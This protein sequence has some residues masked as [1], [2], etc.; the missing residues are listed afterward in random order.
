MSL[1]FDN[2]YNNEDQHRMNIETMQNAEQMPKR[3]FFINV[4]EKPVAKKKN[5]NDDNNVG[6]EQW[7]HLP[8]AALTL[9]RRRNNLN[10]SPGEI[11]K[12]ESFTK[13]TS[14]KWVRKRERK[15]I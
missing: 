15:K 4:Q 10:I 11:K 12:R 1:F 5:F 6:I 2:N 9:T 8:Q 13:T 3:G 14:M 7:H